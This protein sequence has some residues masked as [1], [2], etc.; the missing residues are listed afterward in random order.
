VS[1]LPASSRGGRTPCF[2]RD[3]RA[4]ALFALLTVACA[5]FA[6]SR[7]AP[8]PRN[9]VVIVIDTLRWDHVGSYGRSTRPISPALDDFAAGAVRFERAYATAPWTRPSI[10]SMITGLHPSRHGGVAAD[11]ALSDDALTL[12]EILQS[13]GYATQAIVSN[14]VIARKNGFAQGYD[15]YHEAS[16]A[17][18]KRATSTGISDV[19]GVMLETLAAGDVPFLLF[20]HYFDPHY[21]FLHHD[22]VNFTDGEVGRIAKHPS[23][24]EARALYGRLRPEELQNLRDL[25]A[26]EVR[27][28]DDQVGRL[29]AQI[30][31]LGL[32]EDTVVAIV[33]DHGEEL[34]E[35]GYLGHAHS[36]HEELLRIP[37]LIRA[38]GF[39]PHVV[40]E[41]VSLVSLT[42][43]LLDLIGLAPPAPLQGRS[44]VPAMRGES[45]PAERFVFAEVDYRPAKP[46]ERMAHQRGIVGERYKMV[47]D[48]ESGEV[49][50]F[51]LVTDPEER[52]NLAKTRPE[53]VD[54]L[55]PILDAHLREAERGAL[56]P[57][58]RV[59]SE[60]E[61]LILEEL[62]YVEPMQSPDS[63]PER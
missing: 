41:I 59:L 14:W 27:H 22:D 11:R 33:S 45:E 63:G 56:D 25:Y 58:I 38:P 53:I 32:A 7:A 3:A 21:R 40:E 31:A 34:F 54:R 12:A 62:G 36:L 8:R 5:L 26:E 1:T 55:A 15:V 47:R 28:T 17:V 2:G 16:A 35:R 61:R 29:L 6:C 42:P 39:A 46:V 20:A 57:K 10:A 51:D 44:L 13:R 60:E 24:F 4:L 43:T 50:L 18:R 23:V 49:A 48:R 52:S 19:A 37:F 9:L 30:E